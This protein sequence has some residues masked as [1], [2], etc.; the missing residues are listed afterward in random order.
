MQTMPDKFD[1]SILTCTMQMQQKNFHLHMKTDKMLYVHTTSDQG[2][3]NHLNAPLSMDI[4][5]PCIE[6]AMNNSHKA[7]N[8]P[9]S[10]LL[11]MVREHFKNASSTFSPVN[12]LVSKNIS[13]AIKTVQCTIIL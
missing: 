1:N 4:L 13:S 7:I 3:E 8:L 6:P 9:D 11:R 5:R 12:A 2:Q 10:I